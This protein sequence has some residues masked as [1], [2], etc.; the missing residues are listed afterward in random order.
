MS[1]SSLTKRT[2]HGLAW[3]LTTLLAQTLLNV[4]SLAVLAR[5]LTP[6]DYGVMSASL[7]VVAFGT[8]FASL[9]LGPTIVQRP[10]INRAH[11][12][13]ATL[14]AIG[15]GLLM[16]LLQW[17]S[18][19]FV[20]GLMRIDE[21]T[22]VIRTLSLLMTLHSLNALY[23]ALLARELKFRAISLVKLGSW[24]ASTF[25]IAIPLALLGYGYWALVAGTIGQVCISTIC[26]GLLTRTSVVVRSPS[27]LA[28]KE[29]LAKS[30]GFSV[31][32]FMNY[33]ATY[34]DN[35]VVG[36]ALGPVELGIYS[37]A[38]Y[39]ISMPATMFGNVNRMVVFPAMSHIQDDGT[40]LKQAYLKGL[41]LSAFVAIPTSAFLV[42]FAP[43]FVSII[44]GSKWSSAAVPFTIFSA[45]IYFRVGAKTCGTI[46]LAKGLTYPLATLQIFYTT[47]IVSGVVLAAPYGLNF[48]CMAVLLASTLSF[49][50]YAFICGRV[51]NTSFGEFASIHLRPLAMAGF[52]ILT[53]EITKT[54]MESVA[55]QA[56]I[57]MGVMVSG[58]PILLTL[59]LKPSLLLGKHGTDVLSAV[60]KDFADRIGWRIH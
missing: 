38:F 55:S 48:I 10:E 53:A 32:Q 59:Y 35:A 34:A 29:L 56:A 14:V 46:L 24:I 33:V 58:L 37:R 26:L 9:G 44:L 1:K 52:I 11:I 21:M 31:T 6:H 40:R 17:V 39:L 18:A 27:L 43:E 22:P 3:S 16:T 51:A 2:G 8:M 54:A 12:S 4:L 57:A 41:S 23:D 28:A 45:A 5:L 20:A 36:R 47:L 19:P 42:M 15:L 50:A 60:G 49:F 13:V 25:G 7:I 30:L